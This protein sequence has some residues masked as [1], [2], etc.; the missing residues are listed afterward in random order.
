MSHA[1]LRPLRPVPSTRFSARWVRSV[2]AFASEAAEWDALADRCATATP[3]QSAAWIAAAWRHEP[4]SADTR[5]LLV[6]RGTDLV[7]GVALSFRRV[8]GVRVLRA[9]GGEVS[10]VSEILAD[11]RHRAEAVAALARHLRETPGWDVLDLPEVRRGGTADALAAAWPSWSAVTESSVCLEIPAAPVEAIIPTLPYRARKRIK[12]KLKAIEAAGLE[13]VQVTGADV[14]AALA[15]LHALEARQWTGRGGNPVHRSDWYTAMLADAV[16]GMVA[17]GRA[18]VT[19][20]RIDGSPV[21]AE[22]LLVGPTFVAAYLAGISPELLDKVDSL[23]MRVRHN[24]TVALELEVPAFSM[25]RGEEDYKKRWH[26]ERVQQ[27]RV[28]LA[29]SGGP[30]AAAHLLVVRTTAAAKDWVRARPALR[31]ALGGSLAHLRESGLRSGVAEL[32]RTLPA[33]LRATGG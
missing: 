25:M 15:T 8:R 14:P 1:L 3:F 16:P 12:G 26:P 17:A 31:A 32:R 19:T 10:D 5:V 28:V 29:R 18:R 22:L 20:Y 13:T 27:H 2:A 6:H 30:R 21:A 33:A 23:A 24:L 4:H 7:A 9:V 11:D